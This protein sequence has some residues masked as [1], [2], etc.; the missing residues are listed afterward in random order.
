MCSVA[1][2]ISSEHNC[3]TSSQY[4]IHWIHCVCVLLSAHFASANNQT[5]NN[6]QPKI[7]YVSQIDSSPT[8]LSFVDSRQHAVLNCLTE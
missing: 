2:A 5:N 3:I 1:I 7:K 4:H 8:A 6:N